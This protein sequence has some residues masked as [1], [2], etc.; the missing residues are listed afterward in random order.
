MEQPHISNSIRNKEKDVTY[1]V[2]AY[3]KLSRDEVVNAIRHYHSQK[4]SKKLKKGT[5]VTI[6]TTIGHSD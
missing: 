5:T 3:R 4:N 1:N 2:I 6:V